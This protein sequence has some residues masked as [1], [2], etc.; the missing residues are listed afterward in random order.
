VSFSG[1]V[2]KSIQ[3]TNSVISFYRA[4]SV[5]YT[6]GTPVP[7]NGI[8]A[9][10]G[11]FPACSL[12]TGTGVFTCNATGTYIINVYPY[13]LFGTLGVTVLGNLFVNGSLYQITT[14]QYINSAY[15][16]QYINIYFDAT[17]NITVPGTTFYFTVT[18]SSASA[19]T[20]QGSSA[21]GAYGNVTYWG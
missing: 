18:V 11:T 8:A 15:T 6:G 2:G 12:N 19:M 17:L 7:F 9:G 14:Q 4:A 21:T 10:N 16:N 3:I 1:F 20:L 5:A 13:F